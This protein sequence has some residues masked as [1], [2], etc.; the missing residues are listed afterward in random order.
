MFDD[1]NV[2]EW[3]IQNRVNV[4]QYLF[5]F[6]LIENSFNL[7]KAQSYAKRYVEKFGIFDRKDVDDLIERGFVE[8]YNSPG[9]ARPEFF[10]VRDE[11][12]MMIK[13]SDNHAEEL[14]NSFPATFELPNGSRFNA[15]VAG[16]YGEKEKL[17]T[18]YLKKIK[19]SKKRHA[20]VMKMLEKYLRLVDA[21]EINSMKLSDWIANEMWD[22]VA[23]IEDKDYGVNVI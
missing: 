17:F 18:A 5:M 16:I 10:K 2:L 13:A 11:V 23:E 19:R 9:H 6:F 14:W 21:K 4:N 1:E 12:E 3:C 8:D 15:R 7:P 20:F 22:T